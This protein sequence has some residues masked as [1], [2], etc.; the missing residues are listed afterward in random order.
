MRAQT[1]ALE[2]QHAE[3]F[4]GAEIVNAGE[5]REA[6]VRKLE[7]PEASVDTLQLRDPLDSVATHVQY[8]EVRQLRKVLQP[9]DLVL[10]QIERSEPLRRRRPTDPR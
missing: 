7:R 3:I 2:R 8:L 6:V 9:R 1:V 10:C 5:R 4:E